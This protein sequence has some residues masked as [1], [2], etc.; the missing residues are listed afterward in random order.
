MLGLLHC[1]LIN[2]SPKVF[3]CCFDPEKHVIRVTLFV[4]VKTEPNFLSAMVTEA[5]NQSLGM[6][7]HD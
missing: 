6:C 2:L 3:F 5:H 4:F 1:E 7:Y